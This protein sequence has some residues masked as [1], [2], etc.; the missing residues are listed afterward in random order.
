MKVSVCLTVF[1]EEESIVNL[2]RSLSMQ[3]KKPDEGVIVDGGSTD[4]TISLMSGLK[5]EFNN[6]NIQFRI[7][8]DKG[9]NIAK[10][11][12][13]AIRNAV[14]RIIAQIDA[15]CIAKKDWLEKITDPFENKNVG[16]LA[17]FYEM[18]AKNSLQKA[19]NT[20]HGIHPKKYNPKTFLPSARSVAFRKNVWEDIGG[21]WENLECAGEDT[22]FFYQAVKHNVKIVRV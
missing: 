9:A 8:I 7:L 3:A 17:G 2:L 16:L 1:N 10:G 19:L 22:L 18:K 4:N 11:R 12:N 14:N 13:I 5:S 6:N 21:Y 15:G 20:F